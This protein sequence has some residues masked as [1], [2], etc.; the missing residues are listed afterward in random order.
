MAVR[1]VGEGLIVSAGAASAAVGQ[2][3]FSNSNG[4]SFGLNG[5]TVTASVAGGAAQTGISGVI[6]S[7]TTY[8]SG[9]ISFSNANGLSFGSSAGQAITGSYTVPS[10]AGLISAVNLS[11][12]TT[13]NN[14]TAFV[15]SNSNNVSFGLNGSTVTA[16]A[17][18]AAQTN[19]T[20]GIYNSSQTT[21]QSSSS[22]YDARSLSIVYSG[23]ISGGWSNSSLLL[24][25]TTA[26]QTNQT[27]GIYITA[28]STGQSSSSTYDLRTLSM[29]G[30]GIVSIGWS[31]STLR[32]SATQSNQAFSA[33]GGTSAFQTLSFANSFGVSFSNSGG[34]VA[35]SIATTYAGT[36]FTSGTTSGAA[37]NATLNTAGL[38]ELVPY[39][40]RYIWPVAN[41]TP[42]TVP[43]GASESIQYVRL[44]APLTG[45][46]IDALLAMSNSSSA[47]AGTVTLQFS[48]YAI[49]YTRNASTLSSL[50]SGSTQTTYT[51][52]SNTAGATYLTN[53]AIYPISVPINFRMEPGEY[54]IGFNIVTSTT[55]ASVTMS[56][57]G[58]NNIATANNYAEFANTATSTNLYGG[59]GVYSAATTGI[60]TRVSLS[61]I[62]QTGSALSAANIALVFRNG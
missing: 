38:S 57:M 5:S 25:V 52:A 29:V 3:V 35:A 22:T 14:L 31:N 56:M 13:S 6:V 19:Q 39:M 30:D 51:Y 36:G 34:S 20:A 23:N 45:T 42:V 16:T 59:M 7:N 61:A 27:G 54:L 37:M 10:T 11:A 33:G 53:S 40:T 48:Q 43:G 2:I 62:N 18:F 4:V 49:I 28:Q 15:L 50:S 55:A 1:G 21:G 60:V 41:I 9:T 58:G 44:Q 8:T 17:S 26:A 32:V 47:G 46:R 12:G 24:N